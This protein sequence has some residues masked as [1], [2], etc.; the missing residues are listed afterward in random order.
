[1]P[2]QKHAKKPLLVSE[3]HEYISEM[4]IYI[5]PVISLVLI[6]LHEK[7]HSKLTMIGSWKSFEKRLVHWS[8]KSDESTSQSKLTLGNQN[9]EKR[10]SNE[11]EKS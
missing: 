9:Q 4:F 7:F 10:S 11:G 3:I 2:F 6:S 5:V 8:E 1:M